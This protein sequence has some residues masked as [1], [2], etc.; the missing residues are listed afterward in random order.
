MGSQWCYCDPMLILTEKEI[1]DFMVYMFEGKPECAARLMAV[2]IAERD[3]AI[4][5]VSEAY[6]KKDCSAYEFVMGASKYVKNG[7]RERKALVA[8]LR[9]IPGMLG[10]AAYAN[11]H[12]GGNYDSSCD[13]YED[14]RSV[15]DAVEEVVEMMTAGN[16]GENEQ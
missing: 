6:S 2:L 14:Y 15:A 7:E 9:S 4:K 8:D 16:E 10:S 13:C 5:A 1:L 11:A 12:P 3:P